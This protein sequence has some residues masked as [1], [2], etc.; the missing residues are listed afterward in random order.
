VQ[1]WGNEKRKAKKENGKRNTKRKRNA[2]NEAKN[3]RG[4]GGE[5]KKYKARKDT[6][7]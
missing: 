4:W 2:K 1:I 7:N 5:N 3:V 6:L